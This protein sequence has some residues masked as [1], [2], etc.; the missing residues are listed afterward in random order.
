[1]FF[2][3]LV[4]K[5]PKNTKINLVNFTL[6]AKVISGPLQNGVPHHYARKK[7]IP[8]VGHVIARWNGLDEYN[9]KPNGDICPKIDIL[10]A[11]GQKGPLELKS[12]L[13]LRGMCPINLK[14]SYILM[15][16]CG[17]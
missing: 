15:V 4:T 6:V 14:M 12:A 17:S 2:Y 1:M 16:V 9:K 3:F 13:K 10:A 5:G 8:E 11:N 7:N